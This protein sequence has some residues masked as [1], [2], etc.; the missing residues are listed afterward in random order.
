MIYA[1]YSPNTWYCSKC[2]VKHDTLYLLENRET[3]CPNCV[4]DDI[5]NESVLVNQNRIIINKK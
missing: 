2:K 5:K 3:Y 4:S 1:I